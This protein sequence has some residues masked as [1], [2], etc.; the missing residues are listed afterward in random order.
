MEYIESENNDAISALS[1]KMLTLFRQME[2]T[3]IVE[4]LSRLEQANSTQNNPQYYLWG[5]LALEK[6]EALLQAIERDE[7]MHQT[8]NLVS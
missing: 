6:I 8:E 5:K 7:R 1:H 3:D 4:L 2:A